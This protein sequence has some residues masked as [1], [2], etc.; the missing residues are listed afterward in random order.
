MR[1]LSEVVRV[2]PVAFG[3][4]G[5]LR[6]SRGAHSPALKHHRI[7]RHSTSTPPSPSTASPDFS[8]SNNS[9]LRPPSLLASAAMV[10]PSLPEFR[11]S[12]IWSLTSV[13]ICRRTEVAKQVSAASFNCNSPQCLLGATYWRSKLLCLSLSSPPP[14]DQ[15]HF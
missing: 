8:F 10:A 14:P 6:A 4:E 9:V 15:Q 12:L 2:P 1:E 5:A 7:S 3:R 13:R 11:K